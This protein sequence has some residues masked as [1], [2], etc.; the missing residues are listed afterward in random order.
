MYGREEFECFYVGYQCEWK[1]LGK[2]Y[3]DENKWFL[4]FADDI[5]AIEKTFVPMM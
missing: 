2:A 5:G 3:F 1:P 4:D